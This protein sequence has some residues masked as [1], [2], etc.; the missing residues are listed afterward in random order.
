MGEE[1][2]ERDDFRVAYF[3]CKVLEWQQLEESR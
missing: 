2:T 3:K 1:C